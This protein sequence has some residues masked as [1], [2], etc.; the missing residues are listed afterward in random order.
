[1]C[2][3]TKPIPMMPVIAI[4][5]FL[6]TAVEYRSRRNGLRFGPRSAA[7]PVTGPRR[8]VCAMRLTLSPRAS[9]LVILA[10]GRQCSRL[11]DEVDEAL[12]RADELG[13][14]IRI[15]PHLVA[16][17]RPQAADR[18]AECGAD[19]FLPRRAARD[20]WPFGETGDGRP[21]PGPHVDERVAGHEHV[22]MADGGGEP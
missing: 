7:V 5:Y 19:A 6:P 8:S 3:T 18:H 1:M 20:L 22:R 12:D 17:R 16:Q 11:G 13:P 14:Q 21:D 15:R 4:T 9:R 10:A 2:T